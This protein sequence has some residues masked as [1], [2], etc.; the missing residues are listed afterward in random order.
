MGL[1]IKNAE[2]YRLIEELPKGTG[3]SMTAAVTIAVCGCRPA[4]RGQYFAR[5]IASGRSAQ[6]KVCTWLVHNQLIFI[7]GCISANP[8]HV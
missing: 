3:E 6:Q 8:D 7:Q 2:T 4:F 5:N 1:D